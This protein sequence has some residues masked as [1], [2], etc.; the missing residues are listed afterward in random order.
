M[1]PGAET[2]KGEEPEEAEK[3]ILYLAVGY[4]FQLR[5]ESVEL[6]RRTRGL[7]GGEGVEWG[8]LVVY[9]IIYQN[10]VTK[11]GA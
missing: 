8:L 3:D 5:G 2:R 10:T 4:L 11:E 1:D 7:M 9:G 6:H